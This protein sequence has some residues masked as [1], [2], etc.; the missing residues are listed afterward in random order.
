MGR[1]APFVFSQAAGLPLPMDESHCLLP[2]G[3]TRFSPSARSNHLLY[4]GFFDSDD[5]AP[6]NEREQS[7][8]NFNHDS[9]ALVS[10]LDRSGGPP[11]IARFVISVI[12]N[13]VNRMSRGWSRSHIVVKIHEVVQP[14]LANFNAS[15]S[16]N[17]EFMV[18]RVVASFLDFHPGIVL[19]GMT[20][21]VRQS[22]FVAL[23]K[24]RCCFF[25]ET[26]A[27]GRVS[28]EVG[29]GD[30]R[31][32]PAVALAVPENIARARNWRHALFHQKSSK[33]LISKLKCGHCFLQGCN[34][35]HYEMKWGR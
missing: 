4:S 26:S 13:T 35:L 20:A 5:I 19:G 14:A 27:A 29:G 23:Q 28:A 15:C 30:Y 22:V 18:F 32:V 2:R 16:V 10:G 7:S 31:G 24:L 17:W 1:L 34:G 33:S 21:P 12:V 6:C 25:G 3:E 11:T 9:I 8:I